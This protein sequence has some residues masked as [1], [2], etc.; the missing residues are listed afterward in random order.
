MVRI[1]GHGGWIS[2]NMGRGGGMG[3]GG[4]NGLGTVLGSSIFSGGESSVRLRLRRLSLVGV[5]SKVLLSE[6]GAVFM[7]LMHIVYGW[8]CANLHACSSTIE[9]IS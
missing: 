2:W 5:V 7:I 4:L 8:S 9:N 3:G 6:N 1:L